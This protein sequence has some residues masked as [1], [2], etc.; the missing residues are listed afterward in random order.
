MR[1]KESCEF[2]VL[3]RRE[4]RGRGWKGGGGCVPFSVFL[5]YFCLVPGSLLDLGER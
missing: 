1:S 5:V 4:L 3:K 2:V